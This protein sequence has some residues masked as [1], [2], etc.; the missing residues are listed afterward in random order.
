MDEIQEIADRKGKVMVI[1]DD[2]CMMDAMSVVLKK[3]HIQVTPFTES[4]TALENLKTNS[5][6]SIVSG[7]VVVGLSN[8]ASEELISRIVRVLNAQ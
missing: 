8:Q 4:V 7:R 6:A 1:D 2:I 5:A 3:Y